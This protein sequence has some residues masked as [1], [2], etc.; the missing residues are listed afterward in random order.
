M[1]EQFEKL[2]FEDGFGSPSRPRF[3]THRES[4]GWNKE[5]LSAENSAK[6]AQNGILTECKSLIFWVVFS[7]AFAYEVNGFAR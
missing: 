2:I 1:E 6:T 7:R 5:Y 4:A 3:V